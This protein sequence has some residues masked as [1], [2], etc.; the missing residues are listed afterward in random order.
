MN[1]ELFCKDPQNR[2]YGQLEAVVW[3]YLAR[4]DDCQAQR[5]HRDYEGDKEQDTFS[6]IMPV[7]PAYQNKIG[8]ETYYTVSVIRGSH[9][10]DFEDVPT[11]NRTRYKKKV[12]DNIIHLKLRVGQA[13]VINSKLVHRGG[14]ASKLERM[15]CTKNY[16]GDPNK[17]G[18]IKDLAIHGYLKPR[19]DKW[20]YMLR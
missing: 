7:F 6:V 4:T 3:S 12:L 8:D 11:R 13:L 1:E 10:L 16:P 14:P 17:I 2:L 20:L 5:W 15:Y 19:S 18:P 9:K